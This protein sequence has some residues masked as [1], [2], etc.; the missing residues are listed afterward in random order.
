MTMSAI[1][2]AESGN[3]FIFN[4]FILGSLKTCQKHLSSTFCSH[5]NYS[6]CLIS[7]CWF[8]LHFLLHNTVTI[9]RSGLRPSHRHVCVFHVSSVL[10]DEVNLTC[11]TAASASSQNPGR[12][13][14]MT[15]KLSHI[16]T[17]IFTGRLNSRQ[18]VDESYYRFLKFVA[19]VGSKKG[20]TQHLPSLP[21]LR[22]ARANHVLSQGG[23]VE[24]FFINEIWCLHVKYYTV[25]SISCTNPF[26]KHVC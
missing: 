19:T 5:Q 1:F 24:M 12:C 26:F 11:V 10:N 3:L 8:M 23:H 15:D 20:K 7:A 16:H 21:P 22:W 14:D 25:F 6:R 18:Q 9:T 2:Y 13:A 17:D 4:S